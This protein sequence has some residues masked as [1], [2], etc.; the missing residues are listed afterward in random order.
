[1]SISADYT[2]R[3]TRHPTIA[4]SAQAKVCA[5]VCGAM[6]LLHA[7]RPGR[8][9][10]Q[11]SKLEPIAYT[12]SF[13]DP[14]AHQALVQATFPTEG[15]AAVDLMMP[16]WSPGFYMIENYAT[17]VLEIAART[18]DG[19]PLAVDHPSGNRWRV[20]AQG[21]RAIVV[22]YRLACEERSVTT[23]YVGDDYAV[24]TGGATFI[25][26]AGQATRPHEVRLALPPGWTRSM[27]ALAPAPDRA[28]HH[29][30][31]PDFDTLVDSPIVAGNP[32]VQTF[33]VAGATHRVVEIGEVGAFDGARAARDLEKIVDAHRRLWGELPFATYD[34]LLVFRPGGGGLEHRNSMLATSSAAATATDAGYTRWLNFMAWK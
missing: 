22:S 30:R 23:N 25:T 29:Y 1:M 9:S 16:I 20:G 3:V 11:E 24:L 7:A 5:V 15:R 8:L 17:R 18:P 21:Q 33:A 26:L 34:F 12:I 31:A 6:L 28:A 13:P 2:D 4:V 27:T 19:A 14:S 32:V 10:A